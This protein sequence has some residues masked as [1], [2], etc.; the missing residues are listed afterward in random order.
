[1]Q[2]SMDWD[3][4]L[5]QFFNVHLL[6]FGGAT[7]FNSYWDK[8]EGPIGGL[9]RPPDMEPW[10]WVASMS[11]QVI[12]LLIALPM[13]SYF[14]GIYALSI[15]F[16]WLYSTPLARWKGRPVLSLV[17]IGISTGTNSFL[18]G[19]LAAGDAVMNW[20]VP[21]AAL[22]VALVILSLYPTSQI[23]QTEE[24]RKRGDRTFATHFGRDGVLAFFRYAF[25]GGIILISSGL[26]ID[27]LWLGAG[28]F[29]IGVITG[30]AVWKLLKGVSTSTED[31]DRV[32]R[33]K[34]VTSMA[35]VFV[36]LAGLLLKHL[37]SGILF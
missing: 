33:I 21:T 36:L 26:A 29:G 32:M 15:L 14:T 4:Y 35:F 8:D 1:M 16:F 13:G 37:H 19:Y 22:G 11:L 34:Y 12:G 3:L 23:Y 27:T 25:L 10:M 20:Q 7:A 17:A 18:L 9:K 30:L 24:D 6:L 31:Y 5:I 2:S 28:F